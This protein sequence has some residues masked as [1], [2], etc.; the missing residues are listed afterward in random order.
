M[1]RTTRILYRRFDYLQNCEFGAF[2]NFLQNLFVAEQQLERGDVVVCGQL[3][4]QA[5]QLPHVHG[6]EG[7]HLHPGLGRQQRVRGEGEVQVADRVAPL[8][9]DGKGTAEVDWAA[10]GVGEAEAEQLGVLGHGH[11]Q[12][13]GHE[14]GLLLRLGDGGGAAARGVVV[15]RVA[16]RHPLVV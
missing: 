1:F 5:V 10:P 12:D 9:D 11:G 15:V 7:V 14:V 6:V 3:A 13:L 8:A 16:S 2:R 4:R